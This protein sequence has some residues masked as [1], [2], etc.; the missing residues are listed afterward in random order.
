MDKQKL[1]ARVANEVPRA[2]LLVVSKHVLSDDAVKALM[3]SAE[4]LGHGES[5]AFLDVSG[6]EASQILLAVHKCDPWC[7]VALDEQAINELKAA[8]GEAALSFAP[9]KT[10]EARGYLLV[11]VPGFEECLHDQAAKRVAWGRLK[12]AAYPKVPY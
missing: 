8:F 6:F 4:R 9:D 1:Q 12:A 11:A 2:S 7:V 10:V 5:V 3:A